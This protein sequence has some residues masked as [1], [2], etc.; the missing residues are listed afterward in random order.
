MSLADIVGGVGYALDTPGALLRGALAG[1]PGTRKS[2]RELLETYGLLGQ[3]TEGLDAGDVAGFAADVVL[4]PI[5]LLGGAAATKLAKTLSRASKARKA[6]TMAD[7]AA[8]AASKAPSLYRGVA[9]PM[10]V[11]PGIPPHE[12]EEQLRRGGDWVARYLNAQ[13]TVAGNVVNPRSGIPLWKDAGRGRAALNRVSNRK[14]VV[15]PSRM[16]K[17]NDAYYLRPPFLE[18]LSHIG[19]NSRRTRTLS[20]HDLRRLGAHEHTHAITELDNMHPLLASAL[21]RATKRGS[22]KFEKFTRWLPHDDQLRMQS[23]F[24]YIT[25]PD[26]MYARI[27][28][29][30]NTLSRMPDKV[31]K[32]VLGKDNE[33]IRLSMRALTDLRDATGSDRMVRRLLKVLPLAPLAVVPV[34]YNAMN[35][36]S[37]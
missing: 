34:A 36:E 4:D 9:R 11:G 29:L 15:A 8:S 7:N 17:H 31:R 28:E 6:A 35:Q 1:A 14:L 21:D 19:F 13:P 27:M 20:P 32:A 33:P 22:K 26:E 18:D 5:N 37:I 12:I 2:G 3:N 30:R 16:Y 23:Q 25:N 24:D 10:K